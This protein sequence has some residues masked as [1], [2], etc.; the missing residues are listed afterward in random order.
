[1]KRIT[2]KGL[3]LALGLCAAVGLSAGVQTSATFDPSYW[4]NEAKERGTLFGDV[5]NKSTDLKDLRNEENKS[6]FSFSNNN[7]EQS[8][9]KNNLTEE[10]KQEIQTQVKAQFA[11]LE[12]KIKEQ[13]VEQN[14][15]IKS[16]VDQVFKGISVQIESLADSVKEF[17]NG[18]N[19]N[20]TGLPLNQNL[21][22]I[23]A[24]GNSNNNGSQNNPLPSLT[25][26]TTVN[27]V[28][29]VIDQNNPPLQIP[30]NEKLNS[31]KADAIGA[32]ADKLNADLKALKAKQQAEGEDEEEI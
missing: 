31:G 11:G 29:G 19:N 10:I 1:M 23:G 14:N 24:T 4:I 6:V 28:A 13:L 20:N 3:V 17:K 26:S 2:E 18:S 5:F 16:I 27:Q 21:Q 32:L 12:K 9:D 8:N 22:N 15:T 7:L 25:P 30:T